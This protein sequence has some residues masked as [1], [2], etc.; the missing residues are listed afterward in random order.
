[1]TVAQHAEYLGQAVS[2]A[3]QSGNI[4]LFIIFNVDFAILKTMEDDPQ[5][6]YSLIRPNQSCPACSAISAAMP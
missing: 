4:R 2:L 3:R 5:A 6:G 1:M